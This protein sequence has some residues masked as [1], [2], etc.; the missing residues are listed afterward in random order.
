MP[1]M[2]ITSYNPASSPGVSPYVPS[3]IPMRSFSKQSV[4]FFGSTT[5]AAVAGGG[6]FSLSS[7]KPTPSPGGGVIPVPIPRRFNPASP[8]TTE[9]DAPKNVWGAP[10]WFLF[11][12]LAHKIQEE[13]FADVR[14]ELLNIIYSI[15]CNLPCPYCAEHAKRYLDGINFQAI[16]TK[17]QLKRMLFEFHNSVN[18]RKN[19]PIFAWSD[20]ET[21]Y[22]AAVTVN[23]VQNFILVYSKK[24]NNIRLI[25]DDLK[26]RSIY[27]KLRTWFMTHANQFSSPSSSSS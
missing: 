26:R 5:A 6:R 14:E 21:K 7:A 16:Q 25:A 15:A 10:T 18:E 22:D 13:H 11:H 9:D 27:T 8:S 3:A 23:I 20:L 24:T 17:E 19:Y 12:T 1:R 4:S 2:F